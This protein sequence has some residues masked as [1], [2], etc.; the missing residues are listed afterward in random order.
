M[1]NPAHQPH[2]PGAADRIAALIAA[3]PEGCSLL[4]P[5]YAEPEIF[6]RDIERIHMGHWLCVGHES[7]AAQPGDYFVFD[8]AGESVIVIRGKDATLRALINVCRH[9][10]SHV[11]Y[12]KEGNAKLLV[13]PYHAWS[14][15]LDGRLK[16]A[17]HMGST[18]DKAKFGLKSIHL[19][20]L[21][22]LVFICFADQ[23]PALTRAERSLRASLGRYGWADAR[24]AHR[25]VYSVDA[26][27]KLV[28]ENYQECYHCTPAH[29]EFSRHHATDKPYEET[30]GL[31]TAVDAKARAMGIDIPQLNHWDTTEGAGEEGVDVYHDAAYPGTLTGSEDGQPIAPLM[32]DFTD[33]DGGFTY[34]DVGPASYFLAYPDHGV[35]YLFI[36]REAQ[37][38]DMEVLWLVRAD[39]EAGRDYEPA[40]LAW[41]WDVTSIADKKIIDFNQKGV[42]SRFYEPGP[43]TPME[44]PARNFIAWY[45]A[46]IA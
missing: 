4:Q 36:P 31:R 44:D 33:Y 22:G 7:R 20:V 32:G 38:T 17:R 34:V 40:R 14:Y 19:R 16:A 37:K 35:V 25:E 9:R 11:C 30:E 13:C 26:N 29:P 42:N 2:D 15:E 5:F 24:I 39:A 45:L 43:Y 28:T 23:P 18:I 41:M 1:T 21:E 8:I 46:E 3:Q 27:W 12:E 10:G 6:A